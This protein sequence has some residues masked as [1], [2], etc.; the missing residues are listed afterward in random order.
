VFI[1][2]LRPSREAAREAE[3]KGREKQKNPRWLAGDKRRIATN[4]GNLRVQS[5]LNPPYAQAFYA[6]FY[7]YFRNHRYL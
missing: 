5:K 1:K 4:S 6:F 2:A 7:N 3:E